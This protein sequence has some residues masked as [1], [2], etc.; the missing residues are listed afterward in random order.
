LGFQIQFELVVSAL[1]SLIKNLNSSFEVAHFL[2]EDGS[3]SLIS[4]LNK[5]HDDHIKKKLN[6]IWI[7]LL[8]PQIILKD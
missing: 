1:E 2:E 3:S 8:R 5:L 7:A 4:H 6:Q